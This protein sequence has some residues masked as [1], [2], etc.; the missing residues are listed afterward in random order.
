ML[1]S[2]SFHIHR[3]NVLPIVIFEFNTSAIIQNSVLISLH[4]AAT[5]IT[6]EKETVIMTHVFLLLHS[7]PVHRETNL[8]QEQ[9]LGPLKIMNICFQSNPC[10]VALATAQTKKIIIIKKCFGSM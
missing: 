2:I 7:Q 10:S 8:K 9:K 6:A 5:I 4:T 3:R 1:L